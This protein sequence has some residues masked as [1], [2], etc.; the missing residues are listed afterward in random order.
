MAE[1]PWGSLIGA[2]GSLVG[3]LINRGEASAAR[4]AAEREAAAA[5][6]F[7]VNAYKNQIQWRVEDAKKAGIHPLAA[8]GAP[9]FSPSPVSVRGGADTSIGDAVSRMGQDLGRAANA[10]R[11]DDQRSR[12]TIEQAA[13]YQLEGLRLDNEIKRIAFQSGM[14][15]LRQQSNPPLPGGAT[16]IPGQAATS[17]PN[18]TEILRA[19]DPALANEGAVPD[20]GYSK[21]S[22]DGLYPTPSKAVKELIED[23]LFQ[24]A[25]HFVRNNL[26]PWVNPGTPPGQG[27]ARP[28]H[29][30]TYDILHGY[31]Q[32]PDFKAPA[33]QSLRDRNYE[34]YWP[35]Y[36]PANWGHGY[37]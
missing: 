28:G 19:R 29:S 26:A 36:Y 9:A 4:S 27:P 22:K 16:A 11:T 24:E 8:I 2:A 17:I 23:N 33:R 14:M 25:V 18:V 5:R 32:K 15:R 34:R 7:Q 12:A 31:R 20:V 1:F 13:Q 35:Y 6:E 10:Y 21:T 37:W 30:W 3:G